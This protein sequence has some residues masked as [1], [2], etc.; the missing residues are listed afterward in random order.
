MVAVNP[1]RGF[2][3][4]ICQLFAGDNTTSASQVWIWVL[5]P[6]AGGA[7][8]T[9]VYSLFFEKKACDDQAETLKTVETK[10]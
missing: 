3:A 4:A 1:A 6:F 8:A 9:V 5:A 2:S 7:L 10:E